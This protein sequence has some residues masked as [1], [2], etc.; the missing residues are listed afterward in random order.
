MSGK[1]FFIS[2]FYLL[3]CKSNKTLAIKNNF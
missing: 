1:I 3:C 2:C